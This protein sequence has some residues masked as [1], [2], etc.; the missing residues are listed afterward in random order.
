MSGTKQMTQEPMN[1]ERLESRTSAIF[2]RLWSPYDEDRFRESVA[3]FSRRLE[4][5]GFDTGFFQGKRVL[6]AGCGGGRNTIAMAGLGAAEAVGIDIGAAGIEDAR[7]RARGMGN[8]RFEVASILDIP[9]ESDSFDLVWC[10]GV[11]MITADENAA[12][13]ELTRVLKPGGRLYLLVYADGGLR[14]PLINALRPIA[15]AIGHD[16]M[17]EVMEAAGTSASKQRTF[18]DDL[19]CPK[20]DFY[21]WPRLRRMLEQRGYADIDRWPRAARLDHEHGLAEY[22]NDMD[23]LRKV[24]VHGRGRDTARASLFQCGEDLVTA[25]IG[26]VRWFENAATSGRMPVDQAMDTV[27]G[28]GHHRVLARLGDN[29]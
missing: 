16:R 3:L 20:L 8:A 23:E 18:L 17:L 5:V 24:F 13:D 15:A 11:L 7:R 22:R 28:Q 14:W 25:A 1:R 21:N 27:I 10:A 12:L 26:T 19:Y 6:D 4:A 9:L 29:A 2:E